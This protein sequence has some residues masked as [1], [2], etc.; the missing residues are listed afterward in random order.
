M[1]GTQ[2]NHLLYRWIWVGLLRNGCILVS[3][4]CVWGGKGGNPQG[5]LDF[6]RGK[7]NEECPN[8]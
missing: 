2:G 1:Q 4:R 7:L 5:A 3:L 8:S 6:V